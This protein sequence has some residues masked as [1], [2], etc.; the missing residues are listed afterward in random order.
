[1]TVSQINAL[2]AQPVQ[3]I[4]SPRIRTF[5]SWDVSRAIILDDFDAERLEERDIIL[6]R[7]V[8]EVE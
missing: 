5:T 8:S 3:S 1:M 7:D 6:G 2:P 4:P